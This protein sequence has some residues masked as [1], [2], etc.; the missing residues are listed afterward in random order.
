MTYKTVLVQI[1]PSAHTE[2]RIR[3]AADIAVAEG[4]HLIG[5]ASSGL[6]QNERQ[7]QATELGLA[8]AP[9]PVDALRKAANDAL[10]RFDAQVA[11]LGLRSF[12]RRAIDEDV[13]E[14]L[15]LQSR[16][17][18]L[19]VI[20]Q[21]DPGQSSPGETRDLPQQV[22][23]NSAKPVLVV[24]YAGRFHAIGTNVLIAWD[25]SKEA[26]R[27]VAGA[28]PLLRRA[29]RV[30]VGVFNA[31]RTDKHGAE[32]GADIA[33]FLARHQVTVEVLAKDVDIDI[34]NALLSLAADLGSDLI[35]MGCYSH[36]P[37]RE[38]L[39]GGATRTVLET[40][41]IPVLMAH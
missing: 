17:S 14:A 6:L 21:P 32:P 19:V 35:V 40:M 4:A 20:S 34:G 29:G 26:T 12:E 31:A 27:A 37:L 23:C 28:L 1:D 36:A 38:K 8:L 30:V 39:F 15:T 7:A 25:G 10:T 33:L 41:T 3:I 16:Y 24:P 18:D 2:Q 22:I 9:A 11:T 5:T 13:A